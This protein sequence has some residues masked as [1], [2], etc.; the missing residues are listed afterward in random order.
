[1]TENFYLMKYFILTILSGKISTLLILP[2][3]ASW[4]ENGTTVAGLSNGT[5]G[6]SLIE[7]HQPFGITITN[8]DVLYIS[9]IANHRVLVVHLDSTRDNYAIGDGSE[10]NQYEFYFTYDVFIFNKSLYVLDHG[11]RK[12][13]EMSLNGS[14]PTLVPY[15]KDLVTPICL[16]IDNDGNI[17]VS[18]QG[19]HKVFVF[20]PS[21]V[22]GETVAG[23]GTEGFTDKQLNQP[24]GVFV[25]D[26]KAIYIADRNN[27]RIMK[28]LPRAS[29][30]IRVAGNGA[31]GNSLEQVNS[32]TDVIVDQNEYMYISESG[33]S[34][35]TRWGPHSTCGICIAGCIGKSGVQA[36]QLMSPHAIAFDRHG[37]LYVSDHG[38][39]R[40]QRF[41]LLNYPVPYN[42]PKLSSEPTWS[43]CGI[44]LTN[45]SSFDSVA[46]GLF[47]DSNDAI[48]LAD[49]SRKRIITWSKHSVH[50]ERELAAHLFK[51]TSVFVTWNGDIYFENGTAQG[52]IDKFPSN[53]ENSEFVANFSSNCYD[54]FIDIQNTLYCSMHEEHRVVK[55]SLSDD[56][57]SVITI[58]GTG[59]S[60]SRL[61]EL[62][63]PWGIF[64][65]IHFNLY[66]ADEPN[67]RILLFQR[68]Q[69]NGTIAAGSGIPN[70]LILCWPTYVILDGNGFL[71]VADNKHNRII[72]V[73]NN[74]F[75]CIAGCT[76]E[77]GSASN[78]LHWAYALRFDSFG[79]LYVAD[80]SNHRIQK[81]SIGTNLCI[82]TSLS[83]TESPTIYVSQTSENSISNQLTTKDKS[84]LLTSK[85]PSNSTSFFVIT[86]SCGD[87]TNIG[88]RCN[89]SGTICHMQRPC[90][91]NGTCTDLNNNQNYHCS[92]PLGFFGKRCEIDRRPCKRNTCL[93]NG[94]CNKTSNTTYNCTC[95]FGYEGTRCGRKINY[96]WTVTCHNRGVCRPLLGGY[97]CE[98]L[99]GTQGEHCEEI[100]TKLRVHRIVSK[101]FAFIAI[102]AMI[103]VVLFVIIMDILKYFFA[104]DPTRREIER[105]RRAKKRRPVI[106]RFV[107]VNAKPLS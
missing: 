99:S 85:Y 90:L 9:D 74:A 94:I 50:P 25:N 86:H 69:L 54:I 102:L 1:M 48:Y 2:R 13:K 14:N 37:S 30:G 38:A 24:Y 89:T 15:V 49:H 79:N 40:V 65:D 12:V 4:D 44:T 88:Q 23:N 22:P 46:R 3:E 64:I 43:E 72:Q 70:G 59:S 32:P 93:N 45:K 101:S 78:Q 68:G 84:L 19:V 62:K 6:L 95:S 8:D 20:R 105:I 104:I 41:Q 29:F 80:E 52:R 11:N 53:S 73:Q 83:T 10:P 103:S 76:K 34:R 16:F 63:G 100:T 77:S 21:A 91:N 96:C 27:H 51:Y 81:F 47:I 31:P 35:I 82:S 5:S 28:W 18:D 71:Y 107:Y 60:G 55:V 39:H 106:Q 42:Q 26:F 87:T 67:H 56:N 57:R 61:H 75:Q 98:C 7:L 36:N 97:K 33:N 66:V 58:A 17:Y 92:C